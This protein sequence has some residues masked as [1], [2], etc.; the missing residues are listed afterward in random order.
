MLTFIETRLFARLADEYL[1]DDQMSRLQHHLNENRR[2]VTSFES[3]VVF[4]N[5]G[6][7]WQAEASAAGFE[8]FTT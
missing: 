6:G 3:R 7:M 5:C 8:S 1:S 4:G 2:L